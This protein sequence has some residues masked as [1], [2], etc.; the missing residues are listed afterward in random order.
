MANNGEDFATNPSGTTAFGKGSDGRVYPFA[1]DPTTGRVLVS[2]DDTPADTATT[3]AL[4]A[5]DA[6][7]VLSAQDSTA[8]TLVWL[9]VIAR[10]LA[11]ANEIPEA[12][13]LTMISDET[14]S[15]GL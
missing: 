4:T 5:A 12:D 8:Q 6:Q 14:A 11:T 10:L 1:V 2:T 7:R 13:L 3:V 9:R 15:V